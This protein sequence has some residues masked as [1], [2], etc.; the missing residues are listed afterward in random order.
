M[1]LGVRILVEKFYVTFGSR[2]KMSRIGKA[3]ILIPQGVEVSI[4]GSHVVVNGPKGELAGDFDPAIEIRR[5]NETITV[6]RP[7][8]QATYRSLHG[9][10]RS[11]VA[12]MITGVSVG[13]EK[14]L[15]IVGLGYRAQEAGGK[16]VLQVGHSYNVEIEAPS[17]L[18]LNVESPTRIHVLGIDKQKVGQLAAEIRAVRPPDSYKG[19]GLRYAGEKVRLKPGKSAV[20]N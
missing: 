8:D 18:E 17:G 1:Q 20:R 15:E 3:P 6:H 5:E 9:L 16:L 2:W 7:S 19:K 12:N 14:T 11:L 13:F 4:E 10:T